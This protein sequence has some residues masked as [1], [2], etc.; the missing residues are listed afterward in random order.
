MYS[1]NQITYGALL[2]GPA[3]ATYFLRKN[4]RRMG[5]TA[6]QKKVAVLGVSATIMFPLIS[7]MIP[8]V[9]GAILAFVILLMATVAY[10]I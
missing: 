1:L 5:N 2:G 10:R 9:P 7:L 4:F 3:A 8:N 6:E